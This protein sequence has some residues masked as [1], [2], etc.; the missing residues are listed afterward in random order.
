[1]LTLGRAPRRMASPLDASFALW[2]AAML[3]RNDSVAY[4]KNHNTL[5]IY[6][7]I[8]VYTYVCRYVGM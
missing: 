2:A 3:H 6:I 4:N 1:M 7:Y 8:Y 5:Y